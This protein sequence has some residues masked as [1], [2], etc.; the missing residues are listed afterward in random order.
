MALGP[1]SS[2][3]SSEAPKATCAVQS[4]AAA[5]GTFLKESSRKM[6]RVEGSRAEFIWKVPKGV[7][8]RRENCHETNFGGDGGV[9]LFAFCFYSIFT[10][11]VF[12]LVWTHICH[13]QES[14]SPSTIW[15]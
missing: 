9:L 11:Y 5:A 12:I 6:C 7:C 8:S 3:G 13:L 1:K 4:L 2:R 15:P 10:F 14:V